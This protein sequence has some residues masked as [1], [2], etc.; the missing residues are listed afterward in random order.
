MQNYERGQP[1]AIFQKSPSLH[2]NLKRRVYFLI[3]QGSGV[4]EYFV[5]RVQ[6]PVE[7]QCKK[8]NSDFF[9]FSEFLQVSSS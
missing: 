4:I 7:C 5:G 9:P 2:G 1:L 6:S 3:P 8:T